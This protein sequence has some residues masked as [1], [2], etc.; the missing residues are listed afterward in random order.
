MTLEE[1]VVAMVEDARDTRAAI[2]VGSNWR[3]ERRVV[4]CACGAPTLNDRCSKCERD[5][6]RAAKNGEH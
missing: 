2:A 5:G 4:L 3:D 1:R 6:R